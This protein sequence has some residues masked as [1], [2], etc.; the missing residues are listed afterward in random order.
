MTTA[1]TKIMDEAQLRKLIEDRIKATRAKNVDEAMVSIAPDI[2]LFDV[3]NPLRYSGS[4]RLKKT[5][6]G[7][8]LFLPRSTRLRGARPEF[9]YR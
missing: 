5:G 7:V 8:V 4:D 2:V 9:R 3:V 6:R 1:N